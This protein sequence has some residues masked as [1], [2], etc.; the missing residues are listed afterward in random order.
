MNS[1][2]RCLRRVTL[3]PIGMPS[4]T[5]KVAMAL[6]ARVMTGFWPA[7]SARSPAATE[8]FLE[9]AVDFAHAHVDH[10]LRDLRDLHRVLVAELLDELLA[11]TSS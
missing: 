6:R 3:Q 5:L 2:M 8:A 4:R 11:T 7:M 10:D 1:Y 9:S